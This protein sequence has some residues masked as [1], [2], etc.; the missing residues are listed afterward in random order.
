[1]R[2]LSLEETAFGLVAGQEYALH[3]KSGVVYF[4]S[5]F[6]GYIVEHD[7]LRARFMNCGTRVHTW[8][9]YNVRSCLWNALLEINGCYFTTEG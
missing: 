9:I 2:R 4:Q 5:T 1:M 6:L 3:I 7:S 8:D